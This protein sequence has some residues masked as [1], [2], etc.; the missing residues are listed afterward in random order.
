VIT[1]SENTIGNWPI[2]LTAGSH[3][4]MGDGTVTDGDA[5]WSVPTR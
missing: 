3:G 5:D 2:V 1:V 4:T